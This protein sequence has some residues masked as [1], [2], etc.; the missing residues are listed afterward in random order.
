MSEQD[1][2]QLTAARASAVT[3]NETDTATIIRLSDE[4]ARKDAIIAEQV[5]LIE[6]LAQKAQEP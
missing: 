5:T 2:V 1:H 3:N 4:I 6:G